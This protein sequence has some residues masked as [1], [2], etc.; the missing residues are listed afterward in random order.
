MRK[1]GGVKAMK[2][3]LM[4]LGCLLMFSGCVTMMA[5]TPEIIEESKIYLSRY[6]N[7]NNF[8]IGE[9]A[10]ISKRAYLKSVMRKWNS[11]DSNTTFTAITEN[12]FAIN[13]RW[14]KNGIKLVM[15]FEYDD[16]NKT[17]LVT[18]KCSRNDIRFN[19][20]PTFK[21]EFIKLVQLEI[22]GSNNR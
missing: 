6:A 22:G 9:I 5:R 17:L 1:V 14:A 13:F 3:V 7:G 12:K 16:D 19:I 2:Y 21:E 4:S 8:D 11:K 20:I 18:E 10:D 15:E